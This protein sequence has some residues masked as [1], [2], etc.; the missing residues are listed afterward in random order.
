MIGCFDSE[1]KYPLDGNAFNATTTTTGCPTIAEMMAA[2]RSAEERLR[3]IRDNAVGAIDVFVVTEDQY[4]RLENAL[5]SSGLLDLVD[6]PVLIG[7]PHSELDIC[8]IRIERYPTVATVFA[9]ARELVDS[10]KRVGLF[11]EE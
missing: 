2:F 10:G 1:S 11:K 4:R 5:D 7:S 9:R 6:H 3:S 8:G